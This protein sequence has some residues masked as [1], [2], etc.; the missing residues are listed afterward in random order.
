MGVPPHGGKDLDEIF[1]SIR[2]SKPQ[3]FPDDVFKQLEHL[4]QF[5]CQCNP[6]DRPKDVTEFRK[7]LED[8]LR[9]WEAAKLAHYAEELLQSLKE[10]IQLASSSTSGPTDAF[11]HYIKARFGFEQA[12]EMWGSCPNAKKG[13]MEVLVVMLNHSI[14]QKEVSLAISLLKTL[15]IDSKRH[16]KHIYSL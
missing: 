11:E 9:H 7:L 14:E 6:Q 13:R 15:N 1:E 16:Y 10:S 8:C 3:R 4:Y 5:S 2:Q 12:L